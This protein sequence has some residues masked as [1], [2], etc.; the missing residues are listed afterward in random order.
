MSKK[1]VALYQIMLSG[2]HF[3][4]PDIFF[5]DFFRAYQE[6][7][8][9][10]E[11]Y[12]I[13]KTDNEG[14]VRDYFISRGVRLDK[15]VFLPAISNRFKAQL[16][17]HQLKSK[18]RKL[19]IDVFHLVTINSP[20][21][22]IPQLR[23]LAGRKQKLA[24]TVTYNGIPTA[25]REDYD[26]R[27][28]KDRKKYGRLF[29]TVQFD[30]LLSWYHDIEPFVE[31]SE[32]FGTKPLVYTVNSRF[33]DM[34]RFKLEKKE[35][36]IVFASALVNYKHPM[37]FMKAV[38]MAKEHLTSQFD[39]WRIQVIG[40]GPCETEV[41]E[42]VEQ[43]GLESS[44]DIIPGLN[45]ISPLLNKSMVYVSCQ[46]LENFPSLA[47]NEAMASGNMI[48]ARDVGRTNLFVHDGKNGFLAKEDSAKGIADCLIEILANPERH[49]ELMD[50]SRWMTENIHTPENFIKQC[51]EFWSKLLS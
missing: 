13:I 45:D 40:T 15:V 16:E 12:F 47:M 5:P 41:R 46:E 19:R 23:K 27:F 11:L 6:F 24:F 17:W 44:V 30:G 8:S 25:F 10:F 33:C 39:D 3:R 29:R 43:S 28:E 48:I 49:Q 31:S 38:K 51:D 2:R 42:F 22:Q 32:L 1:R 21:E 37:M 20:D 4:G 34:K 35:K 50:H 18:L 14:E 36:L 9:A 26:S 7:P